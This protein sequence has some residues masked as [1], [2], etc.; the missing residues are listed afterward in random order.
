MMMSAQCRWQLRLV[1]GALRRGDWQDARVRVLA[2]EAGDCAG[3]ADRQVCTARRGYLHG[4]ALSVKIA[5]G[6]AARTA[7]AELEA[8]AAQTANSASS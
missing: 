3:C 5:G 2:M 1:E 6:D 4:L 7:L 8:R